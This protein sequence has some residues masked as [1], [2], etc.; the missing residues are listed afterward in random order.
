[1]HGRRGE[2]LTKKGEME[3][4]KDKGKKEEP[5]DPIM[6]DD[7][8]IKWIMVTARKTRSGVPYQYKVN[9]KKRFVTAREVLASDKEEV[10]DLWGVEKIEEILHTTYERKTRGPRV[11]RE[12]SNP[13]HINFSVEPINPCVTN[14]PK[15]IPPFKQLKFRNSRTMGSTSTQG[16]TTGGSSSSSTSQV[17]TLC[18]GSS[19]SFRMARHDPT[20]RLPKFQGEVAEYTEKHLFIYAKIW[21]EK[22]I[23]DEDTKIAQLSI[24]PR[25]YA[26][27]W[28]MSLDANSAPGTIRTLTKIKKL[29]VNEIQK[30]SSKNRYMN[31]I[32]KIRQKPRESVW[33][34]DQIFKRLKGKLKYLMTDLQHRHLFVNSL[35]PQLKYL[36]RQQKF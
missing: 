36:L 22:H 31:E 10:E 3:G 29:L 28:Y 19:L 5:L 15:R 30:S 24:T 33:D 8:Q 34:I 20:I 1:M 14:T 4:G 18:G 16:T 13:I 9:T 25:D 2:A 26:L 27:D 7:D 35:L 11:G 12:G 21:E 32:I 6:M 23:T 17:S